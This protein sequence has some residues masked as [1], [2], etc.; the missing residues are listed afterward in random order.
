MSS[1]SSGTKTGLLG[2][3]VTGSSSESSEMVMSSLLWPREPEQKVWRQNE[4]IVRTETEN[5]SREQ[6]E[7]KSTRVFFIFILLVY[8]F[9]Y[10]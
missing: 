2:T 3:I 8:Y 6:K 10:F 5:V 9:M 4:Q 1:S 7:H